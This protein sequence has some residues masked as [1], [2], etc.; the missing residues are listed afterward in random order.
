MSAARR[1]AWRSLL[2]VEKG[3]QRRL[4]PPP[5]ELP[6]RDRD[7]ALELSRG[8]ERQRGWLDF[9]LLSC[10][11]ERLPRD[12][13]AKTALRVGAYQLLELERIPPHAAVHTA[14]DLVRHSRGFVNA[15]LRALAARIEPR[16]ADPARPR[17]QV[18]L[19]GDRVLRLDRVR[20]PDPGSEPV[21]FAATRHALPVEIVGRWAEA[22]GVAAA[23]RIAAASA[24]R[25]RVSLCATSGVGRDA[26]RLAA[27]LMSEGVQVETDD[28][29]RV[30]HWCGGR[31]PF[32]TQTFARGQCLAQDRTAL[33][34]AE[35]VRA[36][37]GD[38]VLDLCAGPG[39]KTMVLADAVGE[40]GVVHA[41][42]KSAAR[43]R[44]ILAAAQRL[45]V[46]AIV[47]V[48]ERPESLPPCERV[49]VDAPCSNT[50]VLARRVEVRRRLGAASI[51]A[52]AL[53]QH[54]LLS[55]ATRLV[56]PGGTLVYST[57]SLEPEE[58]RQVVERALARGFELVAECLTLPDSRADGGYYA[59]L[60]APG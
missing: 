19:P 27:A 20:L 40:T 14:V 17:E 36:G 11:C 23:Q 1:A 32:A 4:A 13:N 25:P 58:N 8:V 41:Y 15:A 53:V 52:L 39:T 57:C 35:A 28:H 37:P 43:R 38:R 30:V 51:D 16:P 29:P 50:G 24:R 2:A 7:L 45:G 56:V 3:D 12:A 6:E 47:Q 42:D 59:V 48:H 34:A 49:L 5:A 60:R 31:S 33:R 55:D 18:S 44:P 26:G 54:G 21:E 46:T 10:A 9:V 22:H